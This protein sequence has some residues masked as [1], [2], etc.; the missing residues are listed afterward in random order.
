M[1][2]RDAKQLE[3]IARACHDVTRAYGIALGQTWEPWD[4][5]SD[6]EQNTVRHGVGGVLL[7]DDARASHERWTKYKLERGWAHGEKRDPEQKTHPCLVPFDVLSLDQ[8]RMDHLFVETAQ[9][10]AAAMGL[11]L[12]EPTL[13]LTMALPPGIQLVPPGQTTVIEIGPHGGSIN[14][15]VPHALA[16]GFARMLRDVVATLRP[17]PTPR[18]FSSSEERRRDEEIDRELDAAERVAFAPGSPSE[19][20]RR[21][22]A[23]PR[24]VARRLPLRQEAV[25]DV[26]EAL[27]IARNS[28]GWLAARVEDYQP[29]ILRTLRQIERLAG[30]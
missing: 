5:L 19:E 13:N 27:D 16:N 14:F 3:L 9:R 24:R 20:R 25:L 10:L 15:V 17:R 1:I 12:G 11:V 8:Q 18:D 26:V 30:S 28:L 22:V 7:G 23:S 21:Y 6:D 2:Q 4:L 29:Y